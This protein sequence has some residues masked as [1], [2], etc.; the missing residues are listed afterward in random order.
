MTLVHRV[1]QLIQGGLEPSRV[2]LLTFTRRAAGEMLRRVDE[3]L[4][5]LA[6]S[7]R[8]RSGSRS[9]AKVWGGTFHATATRLLRIHG[10]AIGLDPA[11]TI[12][13]R[14]DSEDLLDA[15][16]GSWVWPLRRRSFP[17]RKPAWLFTAIA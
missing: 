9:T 8:G 11:F 10:Q 3:L 16:R 7:S 13:D 5:N 2:L 15:L 17:R 12:H 4:A 14:T 1:A 6:D